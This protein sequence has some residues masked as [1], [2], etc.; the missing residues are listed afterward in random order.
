MAERLGRGGRL[1][2]RA[3]RESGELSAKPC[4]VSAA[5]GPAS[6]RSN[7]TRRSATA[8]GRYRPRPRSRR[9]RPRGSLRSPSPSRRRSCRPRSAPRPR[10]NPRRSGRCPG[11]IGAR[12]PS[13]TPTGRRGLG[14]LG[15]LVRDPRIGPAV[16]G[17]DLADAVRGPAGEHGSGG[18]TPTRVTLRRRRR[19]RP[20]WIR[21]STSGRVAVCRSASW[22]SV[23]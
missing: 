16:P 18:G 15:R 10:R 4:D 12:S 7:R 5:G 14:R 11:S 19:T 2:D 8:A 3:L 20:P 17:V 13:G 22:L 6:H 1:D 9:R 23:L 21:R